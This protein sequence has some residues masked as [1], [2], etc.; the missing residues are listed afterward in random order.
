MAAFGE[1]RSSSRVSPPA[2]D[3][4]GGFTR[5]SFWEASKDPGVPMVCVNSKQNP[6]ITTSFMYFIDPLLNLT[7]IADKIKVHLT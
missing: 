2:G 7:S 4:S 5:V 3:V 6:R 1:G